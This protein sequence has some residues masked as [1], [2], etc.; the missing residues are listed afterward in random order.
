MPKQILSK[1]MTFCLN[2]EFYFKY[3]CASNLSAFNDNNTSKK[4]YIAE[5]SKERIETLNRMY[6]IHLK[7]K[8]KN[9]IKTNNGII[10]LLVITLKVIAAIDD[11]KY[12]LR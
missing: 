2:R 4:K 9:T 8:P 5:T 6:P 1:N 12:L 3:S 11:R 10:K 7:S